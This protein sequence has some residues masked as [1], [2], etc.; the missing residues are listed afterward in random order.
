MIEK[1]KNLARKAVVGA[2][3]A[4]TALSSQENAQASQ[5]A[6][7]KAKTAISMAR[8]DVVNAKTPEKKL[9]AGRRLVR[10]RGKLKE[11]TAK[12]ED[13]RERKKRQR[14]DTESKKANNELFRENKAD[15]KYVYKEIDVLDE[16]GN[17]IGTVIEGSEAYVKLKK[18]QIEKETGVEKERARNQLYFPGNLGGFNNWQNS[19]NNENINYGGNYRGNWNRGEGVNTDPRDGG[20]VT[21][22]NSTHGRRGRSGRHR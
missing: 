8:L 11:V 1:L 12:D 18:L 10:A 15:K 19:F 16:K 2:G 4:A 7:A 17:K 21:P 14:F 6:I 9:E 20:Y 22:Y 3:L 13:E 5:E